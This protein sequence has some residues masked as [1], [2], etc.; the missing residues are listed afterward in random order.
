M[1]IVCV[2]GRTGSAGIVIRLGTCENYVDDCFPMESLEAGATCSFDSAPCLIAGLSVSL[3]SE[4]SAGPC[5]QCFER[6]DSF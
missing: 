3:V 2:L 1:L 6:V 4:E 5:L